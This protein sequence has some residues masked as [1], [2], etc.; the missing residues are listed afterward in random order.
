LIRLLG[1]AILKRVIPVVAAVAALTLLGRHLFRRGA[2][3]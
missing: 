1:P 3:K 2:K